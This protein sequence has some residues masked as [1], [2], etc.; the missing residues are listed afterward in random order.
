MTL[1][2]NGPGD[3]TFRRYR[4]EAVSV[5]RGEELD[6]VY[7]T[8]DDMAGDQDA[9][10]YLGAG[11]TEVSVRRAEVEGSRTGTM[12]PRAEHIVFW[13]G[14]GTATIED[15]DDGVVVEVV[16]GD[17]TILSASRRYAFTADA[18]TITMVHLSDPVVRRAL[19]RRGTV[20]SGPV[21]FTL[22]PDDDD[23]RRA[24]RGTIRSH[25][26]RLMD[27][28]LP[29]PARQAANAEVADAV[30]A[31]FPLLVPERPA[32]TGSAARAAEWIRA[33]ADR[34]VTLQEIATAVGV[35]ER[36]LQNAMHRRFGESPMARL[37]VER[38]EGARRELQDSAGDVLVADV[39]RRWHWYHL[40]RF[41]AAYAERF[42][43]SPRDTLQ[44]SR[45]RDRDR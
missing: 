34:P 28:A 26:P 27:A 43:E 22:Q 36:G 9:F 19:V 12:R 14:D 35:S 20:P 42:G 6:A 44:R 40:G 37:R 30:V 45:A 38:L 11:D 7:G 18:R 4:V 17:P 15:L 33:N 13:I 5:D 39:A 25:G 10:R 16:P 21:A 32:G 8:G 3:P 29:A 1:Q 23:R 2:A 41:A 31:A 24:L